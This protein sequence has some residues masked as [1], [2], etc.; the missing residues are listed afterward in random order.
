MIYIV[1]GEIKPS[2]KGGEN[3]DETKSIAQNADERIGNSSGTV[4]V[5]NV[6]VG[7]YVELPEAE[8]RNQ[9]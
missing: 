9:D 6:A 8:R 1:W 7:S 4:A 2:P 5:A 3:D